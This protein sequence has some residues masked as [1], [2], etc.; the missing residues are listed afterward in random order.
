MPLT[1]TRRFVFSAAHRLES[2]ALD[3]AAQA[4]CFGPCVRTHGHNYR[5]E[6]AVSGEADPRTG[7]FA[8]VM[9]LDAVVRRMLIDRWDHSLLN[10]HPEFAGA[11]V[12][13]ETIAGTAWRQLE[14]ALRAR[15]LRLARILVAETDEHWVELTP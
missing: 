15:G 1:L 14:P 6:V 13:M 10:D 9:E 5:F 11:V 4:A 7:F 12:T 8:N 2:P 3:A